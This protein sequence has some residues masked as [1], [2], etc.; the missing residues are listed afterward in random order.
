MWTDRCCKAWLWNQVIANQTL[1][2]EKNTHIQKNLASRP[3]EYCSCFKTCTFKQKAITCLLLIP[4]S[5]FQ[6][7]P[8]SNKE[9]DERIGNNERIIYL[10]KIKVLQASSRPNL[11]RCFFFFKL[12]LHLG[13]F[14][15]SMRENGFESAELN[16]F[17]ATLTQTPETVITYPVIP[18]ACGKQTFPLRF[19]DGFHSQVLWLAQSSC[20]ERDGGTPQISHPLCRPKKADSIRNMI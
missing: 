2:K 3:V 10:H 19:V 11:H 15:T 13:L 14:F 4:L 18:M 5:Y 1:P 7:Q 17:A 9:K 20:F 16:W 8:L 12:T 6:I